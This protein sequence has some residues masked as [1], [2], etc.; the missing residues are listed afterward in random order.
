MYESAENLEA[1]IV[2]LDMASPNAQRPTNES[3]LMRSSSCSCLSV[4]ERQRLDGFHVHGRSLQLFAM[5]YT[6][7]SRVSSAE[8]RCKACCHAA[9]DLLSQYQLHLC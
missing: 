2:T 8:V 1:L 5:K 6:F 7:I 9:T 3:R 4:A